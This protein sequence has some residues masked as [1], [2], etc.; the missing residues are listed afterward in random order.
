MTR[1]VVITGMGAL[2]SLGPDVPSLW[3]ALCAGQSGVGLITK[4]DTSEWDVHIGAEI[5]DFDPASILGAKQARRLDPFVQYAMAAAFQAVQETGLCFDNGLAERT[6]V[7]IGSGKGGTTT[8]FE[9]FRVMLEHGPKRIHPLLVPMWI[10]SMASSQIAMALGV[11]GPNFCV[12]SACSTGAHAIGEAAEIIRRDDADVM[13]AGGTEASVGPL[14]V[15]G[16][17][18]MRALSRRNAEPTRASRPFDARR[19]GFVL[20]EGAGVVIL[21][22]LEHAQARGARIYAELVG[23]AAT[24]DAY[25]ITAPPED[26]EGLA[27]AMHLALRKARL[28]PQD[29]DYIN[30]HGTS[31]SLND[32]IETRAIKSVFGEHA[33]R[34]PVS[35]TK[36]MTGHLIAAAGAVEAMICVK[37]I[38]DGVLPPTINYEY[39]DPECDLDYVPNTARQARVDVALSNSAGFG[40]QNACLILQRAAI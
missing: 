6:G 38:C 26:G 14:T 7:I 23:Y 12:M 31:T 19:D 10:S 37:A 33:Q 20:A 34:V 24:A 11:K 21:E 30:A 17:S 36:S 28:S 2:T 39:P 22:E 40:G 18:A 5:K 27:R 9:Q 25:H 1:R 29:V 4:F 8:L 15:A 35:S 16:F 13:I 32:A 3:S